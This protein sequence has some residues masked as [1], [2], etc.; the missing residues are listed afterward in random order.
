MLKKI[1]MTLISEC[2]A[3]V[4]SIQLGKESRQI[5]DNIARYL[6][7]KIRDVFASCCGNNL[8]SG[9]ASSEP[10]GLLSCG[11]LI[12]PSVKLGDIVSKAFALL[13]NSSNAIQ[14]CST[15]SKKTGNVFLSKYLDT[16]RVVCKHQQLMFSN[17][18]NT[19]CN[20]FFD[21]RRKRS[22][23]TAVQVHVVSFKKCKRD[24]F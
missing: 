10:I 2:L 1:F 24:K 4:E 14:K 12:N 8:K 23:E 11:N 13:D 7:H 16:S 18:L 6:S 20:C 15:S 22:N 17:R 3:D 5:S 9:K 21:S 19:I